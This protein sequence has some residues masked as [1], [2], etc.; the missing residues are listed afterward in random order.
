MSMFI[1]DGKQWLQDG[2]AEA[3]PFESW[4]DAKRYLKQKRG[5]QATYDPPPIPVRH[6]DWHAIRP[7]NY[8]PGMPIGYGATRYQ[9]INDLL[10]QEQD[11]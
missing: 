6:F 9:A 11:A 8:E 10:E 3:G 7:D 2:D 1:R 4:G 5:I